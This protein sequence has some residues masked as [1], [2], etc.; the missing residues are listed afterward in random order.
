MRKFTAAVF[1]VL[2]VTAAVTGCGVGPRMTLTMTPFADSSLQGSATIEGAELISAPLIRAVASGAP[3][4]AGQDSP[5]PE[6]ADDT[7]AESD[8]APH[9][10][11]GVPAAEARP[12][13]RSTQQDRTPAPAAGGHVTAPSGQSTSPTVGR[14]DDVEEIPPGFVISVED[15][16]EVPGDAMVEDGTWG[17]FEPIEE[18]LWWLDGEAPADL[19]GDEA[20]LRDTRSQVAIVFDQCLFLQEGDPCGLAAAFGGALDP[21]TGMV[22]ASTD[23]N[24]AAWPTLDVDGALR[25]DLGTVELVHYSFVDGS[26]TSVIVNVV[27]HAQ[28]DGSSPTVH[29]EAL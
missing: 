25:W 26:W 9:P 1:G 3:G 8:A 14:Q 7:S 28:V 29:V 11:S 13:P 27:G 17:D 22:F 23:I 12:E 24:R 2:A 19:P 16:E 5:V 15:P 21:T 10:T 4:R 6:P 18:D 20:T